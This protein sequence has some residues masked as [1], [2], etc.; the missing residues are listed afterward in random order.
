MRKIV[1]LVLV[2]VI[3][4]GLVENCYGYVPLRYRP[5]WSP[6]A[7]ELVPHDVYYELY[8][9]GLKNRSGLMSAY[10]FYYYRGW[11]PPCQKPSEPEKS[12]EEMRKDYEEYLEVRQARI[13]K[14]RQ[15]RATE[16]S[17]KDVICCY[18]KEKGIEFWLR[19]GLSIQNKTLSCEFL[20][21]GGDVI[22]YW[23]AGAVTE[24][25][26][27][28]EYAKVYQRYVDAWLAFSKE[29]KGGRIYEIEMAN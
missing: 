2:M 12:F 13:E 24:M 14:L 10:G 26:Q 20:L 25:A 18:L 5:Y 4:G 19:N 11:S 23:N 3:T 7:G 6:Y 22:K 9:F 21:K 27:K 29:Y 28:P 8:D 15:D 1:M 17:G 16:K